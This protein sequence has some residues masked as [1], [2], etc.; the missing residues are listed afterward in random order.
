MMTIDMSVVEIGESVLV[1]V[2]AVKGNLS[3]AVVITEMP[4]SGPKDERHAD[5]A[6]FLVFL[7]LIAS[8]F[9]EKWRI[10]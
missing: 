5:A 6:A 9:R 1:F 2:L 10:S 8:L 4:S 3:D 7:N